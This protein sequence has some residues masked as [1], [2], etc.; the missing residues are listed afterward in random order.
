MRRI[1]RE[2]LTLGTVNALQL[3]QEEVNNL[4]EQ[5]GFDPVKHW[6]ANRY[7]RPILDALSA[8]KRM[9]G[10]R[11]RCIYCVDSEGN[12]IEHFWP[13]N[14]YSA[15]MYSWDNLLIA[16]TQ[17]G[18]FKGTQFPRRVDGT[19]L[20]IDPCMEDPWEFLDFDPVTGNLDARYILPSAAYSAKGENTV[21]VLHLNSR[22]GVS[23]GYRK[24][25]RR[26]CDLV[27]EWCDKQLPVTYVEQLSERDD[28]GLLG[29]FLHG[30]GQ[31]QPVFSRFREQYPDEWTVC[32]QL[33][34]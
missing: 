33:C 1:E 5:K 19:P 11:Q 4:S 29:W 17:C 27:T 2:D 28:H 34:R 13:K 26:L 10:A 24:S 25:H 7:S 9:V 12:D 18:R 32:Q 8:L 3:L 30:S 31:N 20:L 6:K 14:P 23:A 16:C 21:R 22:E 15:K